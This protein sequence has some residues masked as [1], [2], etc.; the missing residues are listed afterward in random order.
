MRFRLAPRSMTLDDLELYK[1]EFL[2]ISQISN[3]TTSKRMKVDQHCQ[4]QRCKLTSALFVVEWSVRVFYVWRGRGDGWRRGNVVVT[5]GR[6][7]GGGRRRITGT[8]L[9][10]THGTASHSDVTNWRH[11]SDVM[12]SAAEAEASASRM[13]QLSISVIVHY[14]IPR[15]YIN[16]LLETVLVTES[17]VLI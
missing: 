7:T 6:S 11:C 1:L 3:A 10:R 17:R 12:S 8:R 13:F 14:M 9:H 15:M 2:W 5:V 4:R 16:I